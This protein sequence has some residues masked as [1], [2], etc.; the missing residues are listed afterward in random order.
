MVRV[1]FCLP[2]RT[3]SS[4]FLLCWTD[5]LVE[6]SKRNIQFIVSQKYSSVVHFA[7]SKCLGGNI[8]A[9]PNQ[10]PFKGL[11][12]DY[13]MWIDSDI[14]F[15]TADFF[16]LL[17][18]PHDVTAGLYLMEN[19]KTFPIIQKFDSSYLKE[20]GNFELMREENLSREKYI[21]VD[22]AGMGWMLIKQGV[23]E[24]IRYPWF[25]A[26]LQKWDTIEEMVGEDIAFCMS[27]NSSGTDIYVDTTIRV[28]HQKLLVI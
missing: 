24:K 5:L 7:R 4:E 2:G 6:C 25:Y 16:K 21:K 23:V 1:V 28:G 26:E 14:I 18:S 27:L 13:M 10:P 8:L 19:M 15:N 11:E 22:Y 20:H 9:G 17:E 3:Y 12:Y